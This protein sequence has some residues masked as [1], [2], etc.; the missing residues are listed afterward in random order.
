MCVQPDLVVLRLSV[1][2]VDEPGWTLVT[3]PTQ[4]GI[5]GQRSQLIS[6]L[7]YAPSAGSQGVELTPFQALK[8][9]DRSKVCLIPAMEGLR[10]FICMLASGTLCK[11]GDVML[12]A[13]RVCPC[14]SMQ[15]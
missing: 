15:S 3:E 10:D 9:E 5:A 1:F 13:V 11:Q 4:F 8:P 12:D 6:V 2:A 14:S 7:P